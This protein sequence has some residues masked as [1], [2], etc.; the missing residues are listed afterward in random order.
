MYIVLIACI[1]IILN[2]TDRTFYASFRNLYIH[3]ATYSRTTCPDKAVVNSKPVP[4]GY[5][6][7]FNE[8][9]VT[10]L[11]RFTSTRKATQ[12]VKSCKCIRSGQRNHRRA[13]L[14]QLKKG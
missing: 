11:C 4:K 14:D 2:Y 9:F 3:S 13:R 8:S 6:S 7:Y 12:I 5:I 1:T 10:Y